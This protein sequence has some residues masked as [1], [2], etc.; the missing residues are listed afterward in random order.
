MLHWCEISSSF[1]LIR[2]DDQGKAQAL[3]WS[4]STTNEIIA[5][6][7]MA[8]W[9]QMTLGWYR[10]DLLTAQIH[11]HWRRLLQ[12]NH[13]SGEISPKQQ[14]H[15]CAHTSWVSISH[16]INCCPGEKHSLVVNLEILWGNFISRLTRDQVSWQLQNYKK[17]KYQHTQINI[18]LGLSDPQQRMHGSCPWVHWTSWRRLSSKLAIHSLWMELIS[19]INLHQ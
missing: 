4:N 2:F 13:W 11:I 17:E 6:F 12:I 9:Q 19:T 16:W 18:I 10:E 15:C 14:D 8:W 5:S 3:S 1:E 7:W